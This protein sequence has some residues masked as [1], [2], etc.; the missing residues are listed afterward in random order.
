MRNSKKKHTNPFVE[1]Y[2]FQ[3]DR[4]IRSVVPE[5]VQPQMFDI[6]AT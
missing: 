5:S 6:I 4:I 3:V 2:G 1:Y